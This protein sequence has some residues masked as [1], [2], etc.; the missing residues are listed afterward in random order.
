MGMVGTQ[1]VESQNSVH[2][3]VFLASVTTTSLAPLAALGFSWPFCN[4]AN[5][6]H[7]SI[8][9]AAHVVR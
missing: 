6:E 1:T 4:L 2:I 3:Y 9:M 8:D 5:T 7:T